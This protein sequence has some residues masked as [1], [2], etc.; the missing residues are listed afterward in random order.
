MEPIPLYETRA[1][2]AVT[3]P[4]PRPGGTE[5]TRRALAVCGFSAGAMVLDAGCGPGATLTLLDREYGLRATGL[6]PS[7]RLLDECRASGVEAA[8][9]SGRAEDLPL[10]DETADGVFCECVLSLIVE[11]EA[12]LREFARVLKPGGRLVISDLYARNQGVVFAPTRRPGTCCLEGVREREAILASVSSA[13][14]DVI[15]W[16]DHSPLLK[17]LA[18]RLVFEHGSL[19][20]FWETLGGGRE[21]ERLARRTRPGYYLLLAR[22]GTQE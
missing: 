19:S 21:T 10:A 5:L 1:M 4:G 17:Q 11:P 12:A 20:A 16:E 6:D 9:I 18:A 7:P 3:G 14:F 15:A 2:R 13:G 22:K 8:L